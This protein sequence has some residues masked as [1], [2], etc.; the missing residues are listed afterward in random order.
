M[1]SMLKCAA[2]SGPLFEVITSPGEAL[3]SLEVQFHSFLCA[4]RQTKQNFNLKGV[5]KDL[6]RVDY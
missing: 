3:T 1:H 4:E 2:V 6:L 5:E